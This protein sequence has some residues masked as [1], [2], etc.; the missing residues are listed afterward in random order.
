MMLGLAM[1]DTSQ[2][3]LSL[4]MNSHETLY[5]RVAPMQCE[6]KCHKLC[7]NMAPTNQVTSPFTSK[8]GSI[9]D[10]K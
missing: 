9:N 8:V 2:F 4:A 10:S 5:S 6:R 7:H 3:C 1:R